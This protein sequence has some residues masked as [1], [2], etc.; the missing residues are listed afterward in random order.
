[1]HKVKLVLLGVLVWLGLAVLLA[2][3]ASKV[4]QAYEEHQEEQDRQARKAR[5]APPAMRVPQD[6]QAPRAIR[7]RPGSLDP[8]DLSGP[9]DHPDQWDRWVHPPRD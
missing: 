3:V 1:M 4:I 8:S 5:G 7:D 2:L 6:N 9:W